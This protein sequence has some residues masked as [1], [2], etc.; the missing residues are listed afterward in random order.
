MDQDKP[1]IGMGHNPEGPDLPLGL[2]MRLA[3]EPEAIDGFGRL[4]SAEK[5]EL[6]S[7]IQA[8]STG[9][10]AQTRIE[11]AINALKEGGGPEVLR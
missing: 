1:F 2:S 3:Q 4:S 5:A 8:C 11:D 7:Y 9:V 10:E 6:I